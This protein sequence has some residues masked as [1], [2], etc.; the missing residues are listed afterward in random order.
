MFQGDQIVPVTALRWGQTGMFEERFFYI[1]TP[2]L[3]LSVLPVVPPSIF[4]GFPRISILTNLMENCQSLPYTVA[5]FDTFEYSEVLFLFL[6][7]F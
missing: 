2:L 7:F 6:F 3:R 5:A 1:F 4:S